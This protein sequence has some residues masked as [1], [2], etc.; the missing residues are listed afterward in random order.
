MVLSSLIRDASLK[1]TACDYHPKSPGAIVTRYVDGFHHGLRDLDGRL[2]RHERV[3]DF[4]Q[5]N[6]ESARQRSQ[7]SSHFSMDRTETLQRRSGST[8]IPGQDSCCGLRA[9][10]LVSLWS[11]LPRCLQGVLESR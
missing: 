3:S 6:P 4:F 1:L 5:G 7:A 8:D 10:R 9:L 11:I 2:V